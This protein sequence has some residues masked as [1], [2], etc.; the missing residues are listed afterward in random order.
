MPWPRLFGYEHSFLMVPDEDGKRLFTLG[1]RGFGESGIGSETW[2][3]IGILGVAAER[4]EVVRT[5]NFS[6][7]LLY[8]N[9]VTFRSGA[10]RRE[11]PVWSGRSLCLGCRRSKASSWS[12]W[13]RRTD[14]S[15]YSVSKVRLRGDF[16]PTMSAWYE[17]SRAKW[18]PRW[19][20]WSAWRA[21]NRKR[22]HARLRLPPRLRQTVKTQF[23]VR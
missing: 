17:S 9:A 2:I 11:Q 16:C 5:T 10:S 23:A 15:G 18:L 6:R 20:C 4:R 22:C 13:W 14:S 8:S 1:S 21:P 7:D 19:P 3:G 12:L